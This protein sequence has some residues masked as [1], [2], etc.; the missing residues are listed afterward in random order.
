MKH[1]WYMY[2][3]IYLNCHPCR[4]C[5]I[6]LS[7]SQ[8]KQHHSLGHLRNNIW[9]SQGSPSHLGNPK[10]G[11]MVGWMEGCWSDSVGRLKLSAN[12]MGYHGFV[13]QNPSG[14]LKIKQRI[15]EDF[16]VWVNV[17]PIAIYIYIIYGIIVTHRLIHMEKKKCECH[18]PITSRLSKSSSKRHLIHF[19]KIRKW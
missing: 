11:W 6:P 17:C 12:I 15:W 19:S 3:M 5:A 14:F 4:Q 1:I 2:N 18:S 9:C 10:V 7:N 8:T 16:G 13:P